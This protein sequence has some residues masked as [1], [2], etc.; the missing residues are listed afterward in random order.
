VGWTASGAWAPTQAIAAEATAELK[1]LRDMK[2]EIRILVPPRSPT[3]ERDVRA[4]LEGVTLEL[5]GA[6]LAATGKTEA[7]RPDVTDRARGVFRAE[8]LVNLYGTGGRFTL[9][10]DST[11]FLSNVTCDVY[12]TP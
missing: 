11:P 3:I 8:R 9:I 6:G 10:V 5:F 7:M 12:I 4:S 1:M 2:D